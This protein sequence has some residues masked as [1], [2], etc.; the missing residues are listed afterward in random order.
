[1][2]ERMSLY[3]SMFHSKKVYLSQLPSLRVFERHSVFEKVFLNQT[4]F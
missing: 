1:V 4:K 2:F 3:H